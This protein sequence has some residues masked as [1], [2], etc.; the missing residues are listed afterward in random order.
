MKTG[1]CS[2]NNKSSFLI[3]TEKENLNHT[4][5][6]SLGKCDFTDKF[7][8]HCGQ[9]KFYVWMFGGISESVDLVSHQLYCNN[10]LNDCFGKCLIVGW[11]PSQKSFEIYGVPNSSKPE[12]I[13]GVSSLNP[14][15]DRQVFID[16]VKSDCSYIDYECT[17]FRCS[18]FYSDFTDLF[19][20]EIRKREYWKYF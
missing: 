16:T 18:Y 1:D 12:L 13:Y 2:I 7:E 8:I 19:V 6:S 11:I 20:A 10:N 17:F 9:G 14:L 5:L 4:L 3:V 15:R